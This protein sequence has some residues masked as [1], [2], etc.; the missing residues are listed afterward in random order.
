MKKYSIIALL[1]LL[2]MAPAALFS[3]APPAKSAAGAITKRTK[4]AIIEYFFMS[5][6]LLWLRLYIILHIYVNLF[7]INIQKSF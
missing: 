5:F 7:C 4:S 6:L 1:V 2:V 3:E